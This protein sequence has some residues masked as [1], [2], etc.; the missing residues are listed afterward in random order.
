M[1]DE[2]AIQILIRRTVSQ[3]RNLP[4]RDARDLLRGLIALGGD[5]EALDSV[6]AAYVQLNRCEHQ[7]ELIA[8]K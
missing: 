5:H 2:Q 3:A 6:R 1:E 8:A 4:C 7:L